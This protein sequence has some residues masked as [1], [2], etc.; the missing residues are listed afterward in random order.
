MS[1]QS[2][3]FFAEPPHKIRRAESEV[4]TFLRP[5]YLLS[6]TQFPSVELLV[7]HFENEQQAKRCQVACR[8]LIGRCELI[9]AELNRRFPELTAS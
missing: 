9:V 2:F 7:C 5:V 3:S 4:T 6:R 1:G 8:E